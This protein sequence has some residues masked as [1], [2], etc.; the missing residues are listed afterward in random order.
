MGDW[1]SVTDWDEYDWREPL[2]CIIWAQDY[3]AYDYT[4]QSIG[5]ELVETMPIEA[6]EDMLNDGDLDSN[7]RKILL[8]VLDAKG[9]RYDNGGIYEIEPPSVQMELW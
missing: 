8:W 3:D 7:H 1:N 2:D 9:Y 4:P 6:I 5:D